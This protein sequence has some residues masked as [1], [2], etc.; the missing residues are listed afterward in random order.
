MIKHEVEKVEFAGATDNAQGIIVSTVINKQ[1][2]TLPSTG[3]MGTFVFT[4]VGIAM[5][6]AAVI[7]FFT[8][9]KKEAK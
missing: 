8:S 4:F 7:L 5:M 6:A 9:K 3:G 2:F 1:G